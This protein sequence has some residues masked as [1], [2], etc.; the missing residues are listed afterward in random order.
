M[1]GRFV[2]RFRVYD[3]PVRMTHVRDAGTIT[4]IATF[5]GHFIAERDG[6][7]LHVLSGT[8]EQSPPREWGREGT[9]SLLRSSKGAAREDA[10]QRVATFHG[11]HYSAEPS[12]GELHVL[13]HRD[14]RGMP[15][16]RLGGDG[17]S[18]VRPSAGSSID[19][20]PPRHAE[21]VGVPRNIA[22]L[23]KI[24]D[25]YFAALRRA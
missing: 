14:E 12:N 4:K 16:Q 19:V 15:A 21:S 8:E 1:S 5:P 25:D 13:E 22:D 6:E 17:N 23:R 2:G 10:S 7:D 24:H 18:G 20:R 9:T 3:T 11:S